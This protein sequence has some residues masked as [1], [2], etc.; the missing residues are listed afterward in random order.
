VHNCA[1]DVLAFH[2]GEVTLKR[3]EQ[4]AMRDRR[5][6]NR[7]R[8]QKNLK[9]NGKPLPEKFIKQG[10]YAMK[11]MV[12]D[13]DKDYDIDDGVYFAKESLKDADGQDMAPKDARQ[14]VCNALKDDRFNKQPQVRQ[15][16]VR[17]YYEEGYHVDMPVY[18]ITDHE[19]YELSTADSWTVSRAADVE[20]WFY[21]I[22][23]EKSPDVNNGRQF[24]RNVRLLKKFARSRVDWKDKI[25]TGFTITK[26]AEECYVADKDREDAALRETMKAMHTRLLVSLEVDHPVTPGAKLTKGADDESTKFLRGKLSDALDTLKCLD[27]SKCTRQEALKAWDKV[28]N[29]AFFS[30]RYKEEKKAEEAGNAA[31][32]ANILS[33]DRNPPAVDKRGGGTFA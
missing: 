25:A 18:R 30:S 21:N 9:D 31:I 20:E 16:C 2:D 15:S 32:F 29:T 11:T 23:E 14:M 33:S 26:L 22:N 10:S 12:Q 8:L 4:T 24:R 6:A 5:N 27:N 7:E 19:E 1:K 3:D 13:P 28:F 17:I